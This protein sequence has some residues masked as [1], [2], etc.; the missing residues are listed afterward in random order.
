MCKFK[1]ILIKF[2]PKIIKI[3]FKNKIDLGDFES[4]IVEISA[5]KSRKDEINIS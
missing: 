4:L 3:E 2:A 1:Y 5:I